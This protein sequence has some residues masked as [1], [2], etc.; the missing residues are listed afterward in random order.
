VIA[1][2]LVWVDLNPV[3]GNEQGGQRPCLVVGDTIR[4][5]PM[6]VPLTHTNRDLPFQY[7]LETMPGDKTPSVVMCEQI[8]TIAS[9]RVVGH[10]GRVDPHELAAVRRIIATLLGL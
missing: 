9:E 6:V 7:V 10:A 1:G 4:R 5:T 8:R 3:R 2:D